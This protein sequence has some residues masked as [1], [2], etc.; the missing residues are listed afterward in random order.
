[1]G[2]TGDAAFSTD[3]ALDAL[4]SSMTDGVMAQ[5]GDENED[6]LPEGVRP[7]KMR[8]TD[9]DSD[10]DSALYGQLLQ[11]DTSQSLSIFNYFDERDDLVIREYIDKLIM[12]NFIP[13]APNNDPTV[14]MS[15]VVNCKLSAETVEKVIPILMFYF[16]TRNFYNNIVEATAAEKSVFNVNQRPFMPAFKFTP[17]SDLRKVTAIKNSFA[18][19]IQGVHSQSAQFISEFLL[20]RAAS[21]IMNEVKGK[22]GT[23][24]DVTTET[25]AHLNILFFKCKIEFVGKFKLK[26]VDWSTYK[27]KVHH[28]EP[29]WRKEEISP[30]TDMENRYAAQLIARVKRGNESFEPASVKSDFENFLQA[31]V[32]TVTNAKTKTQQQRQNPQSRPPS[33]SSKKFNQAPTTT[34]ANFGGQRKIMQAQRKRKQPPKHQQ[35]TPLADEEDTLPDLPSLLNKIK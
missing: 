25:K 7:P 27:S 18:M 17:E 32:R 1:M 30:P 33:S 10:F 5:E 21:I 9:T 2:D 11:I 12:L 14:L 28:T 26:N 34:P 13:C 35:S 19:Q 16:Q 31:G 29:K 23:T 6:E 24:G 20:I 22:V 8:K 15:S 3:P 4:M